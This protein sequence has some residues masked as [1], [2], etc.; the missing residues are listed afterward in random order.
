MVDGEDQLVAGLRHY[1]IAVDYAAGQVV[2][3]IEESECPV[4]AWA[5]SG[6][7]SLTGWPGE[8]PQWPK[9]DVIGRLTGT[10]RV[11]GVIA[12]QFGTDVSVDVGGLLTERAKARGSDRRGST[13]VGGHCQLV[14]T[15]DS[16]V[17][18]NLA[19]TSDFDLLPALTDGEVSAGST[20]HDRGDDHA[21]D[22][23]V[24][25]GLREFARHRWGSDLTAAAQLLGIPVGHLGIAPVANELPWTITRLGEA[26]RPGPRFP[27]IVD[28][29]ALWSGPLCAQLLGRC[30]AHVVKVEDVNRPDAARQGDPRMFDELHGGHDQ[31]MLDFGSPTDRRALRTLVDSADVVIEAS[32][33]RALAAL[34]LR[35][36]QF[37]RARAGR[38]W[39]SITGYGRSG[40]RSNWVA[41]GDDAAVAGGLVGRSGGRPVFC[42]DAIADPVSGLLAATGTL[43]SIAHGGGHLIDCSMQ[44][45]S[46]FVAGGGTCPG[47]HRVE[48]RGSGW[49]AY[50]DDVSHEVADRPWSQRDSMPKTAHR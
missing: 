28:F 9:G 49:L 50:H 1:G 46:A 48:R 45:S 5:A 42:A 38:T 32:R 21:D 33:P 3:R 44:K 13:A 40:S 26:V 25:Q 4:L 31:L 37:L 12:R 8:P 15:L 2:T 43:A 16:W 19:R 6:A 30:G 39:V 35:P 47:Q 34:G 29:S 24:W 27:M 36:E 10:A 22:A 41:F 17:A 20:G 23:A 18:I 7:M 14:R 11:F